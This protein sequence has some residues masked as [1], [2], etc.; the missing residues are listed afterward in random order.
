MVRGGL[1][2]QRT[3]LSKVKEVRNSL[4][5]TLEQCRWSSVSGGGSPREVNPIVGSL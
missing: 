5:S 3:D 1:F 2:W 4:V